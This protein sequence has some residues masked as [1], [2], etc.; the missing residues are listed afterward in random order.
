VSSNGNGSQVQVLAAPDAALA[1]PDP[2]IAA[3]DPA[4]GRDGG[5]PGTPVAVPLLH[6]TA[7]AGITVIARILMERAARRLTSAL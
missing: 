7:I 2:A 5:S 1:A 4:L 6:A 3:P